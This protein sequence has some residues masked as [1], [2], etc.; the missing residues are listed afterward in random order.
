MAVF[1]SY[2]KEK[3]AGKNTKSLMRKEL[4]QSLRSIPT[5]FGSTISLV[6]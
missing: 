6:D 4:I 3:K 1:I 2:H 5:M